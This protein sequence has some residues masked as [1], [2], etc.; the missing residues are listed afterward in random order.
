MSTANA[1]DLVRIHYTAMT[2]GGG[3]F[4]T[5]AKRNPLE[6]I[7]G[8]DAVIQ[9][10]SD[11]VIGMQ[12]GESK[13]VTITPEDGFGLRDPSLEQIVPRTFLPE[14]LSEGDQTTANFGDEE[15]DVWVQRLDRD[16]AVV[17]ANHPLAG[18]TLVYEIE[19]VSFEPAE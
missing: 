6:F 12:V 2:A 16:D 4:E 8:G 10:V 19:L 11:A 5:S 15:L 1:G 14:G 9:G 13:K 17:D 18:E 3:V 7:A